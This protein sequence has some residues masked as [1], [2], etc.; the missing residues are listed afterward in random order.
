MATIRKPQHVQVMW[1]Y[2]YLSGQERPV[3]LRWSADDVVTL[4]R[5]R[6][7]ELFSI[8]A[9]DFTRATLWMGHLRL[10]HGRRTFWL[11]VGGSSLYW[12]DDDT[13]SSY[14]HREKTQGVPDPLW[15]ADQLKAAGVPVKV[16]GP[17]WTLGLVGALSLAIIVVVGVIAAIATR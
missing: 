8:P 14:T 15:W 1:V 13:E 16:R 12:Q 10:H 9:R 17:S 2:G 4:R 11:N 5:N 3:D 6:E 7:T